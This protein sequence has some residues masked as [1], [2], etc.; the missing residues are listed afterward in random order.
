MAAMTPQLAA[1]ANANLTLSNG[2]TIKYYYNLPLTTASSK[3]TAAVINI[4]GTNRNASDYDKYIQS[5]ASQAGATGTT[6]MITPQFA[7]SGSSSALYWSDSGWKYGDNSTSSKKLSS[8]A[9][10]DEMIRKLS[11]KSRFPNLKKITVV[12]HS[13]GGQFVQRYA[14]GGS[15]DGAVSVP[16]RYVV[17]NPSSYMY[18]N[19]YRI[20]ASGQWV[21]PTNCA[22]YDEYR[23]G[24]KDLGDYPYMGAVGAS[25]LKSRYPN[26]EVTY[27]LGTADTAADD[28]MDTTCKAMLQGPNR[29]QR[30]VTFSSYM[31]KY[32]SGNR[33]KALTVAGVGHSAS[34]MY[35]STN[36]RQA[37]FF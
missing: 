15:A 4:H 12:G 23:Y 26:R 31:N 2:G 36:G 5:A 1:A 21:T 9:V 30:G 18:L 20:S 29:Y 22:D 32:F 8:F 10:V 34:G 25:T 3:V 28:D 27:L 33:H 37:I 19:G 11:D 24:L 35:G 13:A 16:V 7:A 6:I 17:A 14:A